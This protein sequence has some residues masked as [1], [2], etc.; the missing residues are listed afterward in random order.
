MHQDR[1]RDLAPTRRTG[2]SECSAPWNTIAASSS[3]PRA[4]GPASSCR[5]PRRRGAPRPRP[6]VPFGSSRSTA[7]AIVDL[8]Q[9]DSPASPSVSPGSRS[10][11]ARRAPPGRPPSARY[12]TCRSRTRA[13]AVAHGVAVAESRWRC[14]RGRSS[15]TQAWVEDLFERPPAQRERQHDGDDRRGRRGGSTTRRSR[16]IAPAWNAS[17]SVLPHDGAG[18]IAEPEERERRLGEDRDRH[19]RA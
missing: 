2:L 19:R 10:K 14:R 4:A 5:R 12:V 9:P 18:R 1:L 17:S 3:A 11:R 16:L 15:F 6:C 7:P 13:A 8:P